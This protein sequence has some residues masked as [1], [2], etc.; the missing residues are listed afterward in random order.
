[1]SSI[2]RAPALLA[3]VLC[4]SACGQGRSGEDPPDTVASSSAVTASVCPAA[5]PGVE[6]AVYGD[7]LESCFSDWSWGRHDLAATE[8]VRSGS[9]S[10]RF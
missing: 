7:A 10:I 3:V 6:L 2:G 4:L 5:E 9:R 1:M 8:Q